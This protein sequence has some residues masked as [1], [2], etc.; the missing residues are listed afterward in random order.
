MSIKAITSNDIHAITSGQVIT[1][2]QSCIKELLENSIDAHAKQID[3][4]VRN[5]GC[6]SIEIQDDGDGIDRKDFESLC[7]KNYTSKIS[8]FEDI[9]SEQFSTLGFRGEALSSICCISKLRIVSA[10][11]DTTPIAYKLEYD[12]SGKLLTNKKTSRNRG[13]T[14]T[15]EDFFYNLPVRRKNLLKNNKRSFQKC[16]QMIQDYCIINSHINIK[17]WHITASNR[18]NLVL[19]NSS[20]PTTLMKNLVVLFGAQSLKGVEDI[21]CT[22]LVDAK[23]SFIEEYNFDG[24][25]VLLS[26]CI[27]KHTFGC[28]RTSKDKQFIFINKRPVDYPKIVNVVNEAYKTFNNVQFPFFVLNFEINA[29]LLDLNVTPDKKTVLIH[30]EPSFLSNL[31]DCLIEY[32]NKQEMTFFPNSQVMK[33]SQVH[34]SAGATQIERKRKLEFDDE[35]EDVEDEADPE[36]SSQQTPLSTPSVSSTNVSQY[37]IEVSNPT[38]VPA[39]ALNFSEEISDSTLK[40]VKAMQYDNN[41][42]FQESQKKSL[43]NEPHHQTSDLEKDLEAIQKDDIREEG[44]YRKTITST[45]SRDFR[46]GF[47]TRIDAFAHRVEPA[48][49]HEHCHHGGLFASDDEEELANEQ[50]EEIVIDVAGTQTVEKIKSPYAS[51][52]SKSRSKSVDTNVLKREAGT[53]IGLTLGKEQ[54]AEAKEEEEGEEDYDND[55]EVKEENDDE[56]FSE[57]SE[58]ALPQVLNERVPQPLGGLSTFSRPSS[59]QQ[60]ESNLHSYEAKIGANLQSISNSCKNSATFWQQKHMSLFNKNENIANKQQGEEYLTLTV[61]KSDFTQMKIVGQFNLGFIICTRQK[62]KDGKYD[63]FIIDQHASDEKFNFENLQKTTKFKSQALIQPKIMELSVIDE[64]IVLDNLK[65]FELNG[66]RL[67]TQDANDDVFVGDTAENKGKIAIVSLPFS[68]KTQFSFE[69]FYELVHLV[70]NSSNHS[71]ETIRCSKIR[72]MFAMR[73]C[74]MSIMVGKPLTMKTM[75]KVVNNLSLLD[76]PWNCPHGRPTMRHLMELKDWDSFNADYEL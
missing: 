17:C 60:E 19:A 63:L 61:S 4:T 70:K 53:K 21:N 32:Y 10:T 15:V 37:Q 59:S 20:R 2:L 35:K 67:K 11:A 65:T 9:A 27:S 16:V 26:G 50:E 40:N 46:K 36:E 56:A 30:N 54:E 42:S 38:T 3:I 22:I 48:H 57:D 74:R 71:N 33:Q 5:Y 25:E 6:D 62:T 31:R 24:G 12:A 68:K 39:P 34:D 47:Q 14:T 66:F 45:N 49:S 73:S 43:S 8:A 72:A 29:N 28:G 69:D 58:E 75:E 18:K 7:L 1:D 55:D 41:L 76:K 64:L 23:K 52:F 51:P 13:T 44:Y